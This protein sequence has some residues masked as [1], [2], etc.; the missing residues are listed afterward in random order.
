MSALRQASTEHLVVRRAPG[1]KLTT[2]G[3]HLMRFIE[4]CEARH[5]GHITT[6]LALARATQTSW[7]GTDEVQWSRRLM[8]RI[9]AR[10]LKALEPATE[11]PPVEPRSKS[12]PAA[13]GYHEA[14]RC[15]PMCPRYEGNPLL[16]PDRYGGRVLHGQRRRRP[17]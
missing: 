15:A 10:H 2:Q 14:L 8:V 16:G 13:P 5:A 17:L 1:F 7:G 6:E 4:F 9:F 11:I 12:L 3:R